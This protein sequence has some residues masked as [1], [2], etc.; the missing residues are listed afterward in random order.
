MADS[1]KLKYVYKDF[2]NT[3]VSYIYYF[4]LYQKKSGIC[5]Y[6]RKASI[7]YMLY[8]IY[9]HICN[10]SFHYVLTPYFNRYIE[11]KTTKRVQDSTFPD[12]NQFGKKF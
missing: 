3:D 5:S 10:F 2:L 6:K 8:I 11:K 4:M 1:K 12:L 9:L 7:L